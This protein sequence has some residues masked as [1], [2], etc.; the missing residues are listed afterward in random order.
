MIISYC[1]DCDKCRVIILKT[2]LCRNNQAYKN[3]SIR[4]RNKN[5]YYHYDIC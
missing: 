2:N 1:D 5:A 4:I 3:D